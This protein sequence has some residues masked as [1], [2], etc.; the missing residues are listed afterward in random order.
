[1]KKNIKALLVLVAVLSLALCV[2]VTAIAQETPNYTGSVSEAKALLDSAKPLPLRQAALV[3][4]E[5]A[6]YLEVNPINPADSGY[7]AFIEEYAGFAIDTALYYYYDLVESCDGTAQRGVGLNRYKAFVKRHPVMKESAE[8][9]MFLGVYNA[10]LAEHAEA[11]QE[12]RDKVADHINL[13]EYGYTT[14]IDLGYDDGKT[15]FGATQIRPEGSETAKVGLDSGADG[16]NKYIT[17][18]HDGNESGQC[19]FGY[20]PTGAT[21]GFVVEFDIT[22]FGELP[23]VKTAFETGSIN[24][25]GGSKKYPKYLEIYANGDIVTADGEVVLENAIVKGEWLHIAIAFD[26]AEYTYT[27]FVE[28]ELIHT[29]SAKVEGYGFVPEMIRVGSNNTKGELSFDNMLIYY[30]TT[31]RDRNKLKEMSNDEAF[32]YYTKYLA[33]ETNNAGSRKTAYDSAGALVGKYW[34]SGA[35]GAAGQYLTEDAELCSAVDKY[36]AFDYD[37]VYEMYLWLNLDRYEY[38]A[39]L[40]FSY[41]RK[42]STLISRQSA[43]AAITTF[44]GKIT[45]KTGVVDIPVDYECYKEIQKRVNE[46][47]ELIEKDVNINTFVQKMHRFGEANTIIALERYYSAAKELVDEGID[48]SVLDKAGYDSFAEA[49]EK[50]LLAKD[51]LD[52]E[53]KNY[54]SEVIIGCV[55]MIKAYDTEDEWLE[56]YDYINGYLLI[57]REILAENGK[58]YNPSY[59]GLSEALRL[60]NPIND[61]FY[62]NLQEQHAGVLTEMLDKYVASPSYAERLGVCS[63][64]KSYLGSNDVQMDHEL[65]APLIVRYELY[66]EELLTQESNYAATLI[67]NSYYFINIVNDMLTMS[68]YS[69][70]KPLYD[71]AYALYFALD[72]SVPNA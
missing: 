34:K 43:S 18:R 4:D 56:N 46:A 40:L 31:I 50:Y 51:T 32:L 59:K 33:D 52:A 53:F 65:I 7:D 19:Y 70:I 54:Y 62:N 35:N 5:L 41:E 47:N 45:T 68:T 72:A 63:Y 67:Q 38:L 21:D 28:D 64:I 14:V 11:R 37:A 1:M 23:D 48:L 24:H 69:E 8:Y 44:I 42:P 25:P 16:S 27:L 22:T 55:D 15:G 49:Y 17:L 39:N 12:E 29:Y 26:P 58:E 71:E 10:Y 36:L 66:N 3:L 57:I 30:G 2:A 13:D 9:E 20:R 60:Y 6:E 61:Y